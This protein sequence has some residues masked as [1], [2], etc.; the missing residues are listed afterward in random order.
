[1]EAYKWLWLAEQSGYEDT[2][3]AL[4]LLKPQMTSEQITDGQRLADA[5][6][7]AHSHPKSK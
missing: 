2:Q 5:W 3:H 4:E 7:T 1:V 6:N